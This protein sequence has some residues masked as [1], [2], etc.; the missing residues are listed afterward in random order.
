MSKRTF[1]INLGGEGLVA[2]AKWHS[3]PVQTKAS[4]AKRPSQPLTKH[5][6]RAQKDQ[7]KVLERLSLS[8]LIIKGTFRHGRKISKIRY[9]YDR[10]MIR[11]PF[12][13]IFSGLFT[14]SLKISLDLGGGSKDLTNIFQLFI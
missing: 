6:P 10:I 11:P 5:W 1:D 12:F 14:Q 13:I 2:A 4:K 8:Q 3:R 9:N 7:T